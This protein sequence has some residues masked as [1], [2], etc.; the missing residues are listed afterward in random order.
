MRVGVEGKRLSLS[1]LTTGMGT[2]FQSHSVDVWRRDYSTC[3]RT[4]SPSFI[5][6]LTL[7]LGPQSDWN[8]SRDRD[9][10]QYIWSHSKKGWDL[11]SKDKEFIPV[12]T[13]GIVYQYS[14]FVLWRT[15]YKSCHDLCIVDK[16]VTIDYHNN[17]F[18]DEYT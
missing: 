5:V 17:I 12:I 10:G 3:R 1:F 13:D 15:L 4:V 9:G 6:V 2:V 18:D 7:V 11:E 16:L 8:K 14:W